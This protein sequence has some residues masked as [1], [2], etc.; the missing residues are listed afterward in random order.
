MTLV[1][2]SFLNESKELPYEEYEEY[3]EALAEND[4]VKLKIL[5]FKASPEERRIMVN[6]RFQL[7]TDNNQSTRAVQKRMSR[8]LLVTA[9]M[10]SVN[11]M[12]FLVD[13]GTDIFQENCFGENVIHSLVASSSLELTPEENEVKFH[14]TITTILDKGKV[15]KLLMHEDINGLR[16]L[17][18]AANLGCLLLFKAIHLTPDVYVQNII[19][20]GVYIE[21]WIDVTEY[22]SYE[23][24]NRRYKAPLRLFAHLDKNVASSGKHGDILHCDLIKVWLEAKSNCMQIPLILMF[25]PMVPVFFLF[26]I[27]VTFLPSRM[28][29][30]NLTSGVNKS[31]GQSLQ[32][33]Q[34]QNEH[35]YFSVCSEVNFAL[36]TFILI[37]SLVTVVVLPILLIKNDKILR[38]VNLKDLQKDK[39][40]IVNDRSF[41]LSHIFC[42]ILI[43]VIEIFMMVDNPS[44][45]MFLNLLI[46]TASGFSSWSILYILQLSSFI[47]YFSIAMQKMVWV[48]WKFIILF[49]IIFLPFVHTFYRLLQGKSGCAS[50]VFSPSVVEHYHNTFLMLLNMVDIT[51]FKYETFNDKYYLV[52]L[53]H[54]SY[55]FMLSILLINFLIALLSHSISEVMQ[56]KELHMLIQKLT[57]I[58]MSEQAIEFVRLGCLVKYAQKK[59]FLVKNGKIFLKMWSKRV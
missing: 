55:V 34:C 48:L 31:Y 38:K 3:F 42:G 26:L 8:P 50:E 15:K 33:A 1:N 54:V 51:Q 43:I 40:F 35:L 28:D 23:L 7:H 25:A 46:A 4:V 59:H 10:G 11:A 24:G 32:T 52:L 56:N 17:E 21:S 29:A 13:Q 39:D 9:L 44:T 57:V 5:F 2:K 36:T 37:N 16:P 41:H 53:A 6:G 20:R 12:K 27:Q 14:E 22:E 30:H 49:V 45:D 47:G 58:T 18:M 19:K